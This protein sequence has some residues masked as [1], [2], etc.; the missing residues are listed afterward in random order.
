MGASENQGTYARKP[1][2]LVSDMA[3]LKDRADGFCWWLPK[4]LHVPEDAL[5]RVQGE[6]WKRKQLEGIFERHRAKHGRWLMPSVDDLR[7]M[8]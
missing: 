5:T 7:A 3:S 1:L 6:S 4:S 8:P 2:G